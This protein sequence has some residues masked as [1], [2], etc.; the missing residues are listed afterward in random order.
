MALM[1]VVSGQTPQGVATRFSRNHLAY[2]RV[3]ARP[4]VKGKKCATG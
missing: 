4:A 2:Q 1:E 3:L